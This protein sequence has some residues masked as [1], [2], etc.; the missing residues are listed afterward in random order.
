M[1]GKILRGVYASF[2]EYT[3]A[4]KTSWK[5]YVPKVIVIFYKRRARVKAS[6]PE[7]TAGKL[8]HKE[9]NLVGL[10]GC[11]RRLCQGELGHAL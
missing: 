7:T 11:N 1:V 3:P 8:I 6:T 5:L 2:Y 4:R 10:I 9:M